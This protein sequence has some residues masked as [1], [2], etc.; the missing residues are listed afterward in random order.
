[1]DELAKAAS[2]LQA[3]KSEVATRTV[4][5]DNAETKV[6]DVLTKLAG[7]V[8]SVAGKD[9]GIITSAGMETKAARSA[10]SVPAPPLSLSA[11]AGTHEGEIS[12]T[13]KSVPSARSYT[14]E[15]SIDPATAT[16]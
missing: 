4:A 9:E 8:E 14:I 5:Q 12:L 13:W 11:S 6:N 10:P 2:S 7:Y 3:A 1:M 15:C 16:S